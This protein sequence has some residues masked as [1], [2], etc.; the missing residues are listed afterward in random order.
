M[1]NSYSK[2][3]LKVLSPSDIIFRDC[4]QHRN[5]DFDPLLLNCYETLLSSPSR[6]VFANFLKGIEG[7]NGTQV[8]SVLPA[9]SVTEM[10]RF[11]K[12]VPYEKKQRRDARILFYIFGGVPRFCYELAYN[13]KA[14]KEFLN[15][16]LKCK[17]QPILDFNSESLAI[18]DDIEEFDTDSQFPHRLLLEPTPDYELERFAFPSRFVEELIVVAHNLEKKSSALK[19]LT[20]DEVGKIYWRIFEHGCVHTLTSQLDPLPMKKAKWIAKKTVKK[21][22]NSSQSKTITEYSLQWVG[23]SKLFE[24]PHRPKILYLNGFPE[25]IDNDTLFVSLD[26]INPAWDA[27][28]TDALINF[29]VA[30][31]HDC[32]TKGLTNAQQILGTPTLPP[33]YW[34]VR[35]TDF[36]HRN[37]QIT[38][39]PEEVRQLEH[40]LVPRPNPSEQLLREISKRELIAQFRKAL[41]SNEIISKEL[42]GVA[43]M[44]AQL[45]SVILE[46]ISADFN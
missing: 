1:N 3:L 44:S 42:E 27:L 45:R 14:W 40:Y 4:E 39:R 26:P 31:T 15:L 16:F 36:N 2:T 13:H 22:P 23:E 8:E 32:N 19:F 12:S 46:S 24:L 35:Q 29:T 21:V 25:S 41:E 9:F 10:K 11:G 37:F 20:D 17:T 6:K 7:I 5:R 33:F 38:P 18:L 34:M 43:P 30:P 28:S